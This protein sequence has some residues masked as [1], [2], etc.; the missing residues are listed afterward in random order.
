MSNDQIDYEAIRQRAE[1][2][3]KARAELVLHFSIYLIVNLI[4]WA[5]WIIGANAFHSWVMA[6]PWPILVTLI[7]GVAVAIH[8]AYVYTQT[9]ML[10][11]MRET[12]IQQ[13]MQREMRL[14][15]MDTQAAELEKPK[16]DRAVRLSDDGEMVPVD[17]AEA[18]RRQQSGRRSN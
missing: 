5:L 14:R 6:F 18:D 10:D 7:W 4:L 16:R 3:A 1:K 12:A 13:E 17:E 11:T 8:G 15:G 2:R 9:N